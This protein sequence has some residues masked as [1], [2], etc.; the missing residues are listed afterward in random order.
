MLIFSFVF[1]FLMIRRPPI[2]TRT[3]TLFPYTTLCRSQRTD[4]G[5]APEDSEAPRRAAASATLWQ[6]RL[7]WLRQIK[8]GR[9]DAP[10]LL[11]GGLSSGI[12]T[13]VAMTGH[14]LAASNERHSLLPLLADLVISLGLEELIARRLD[15]LWSDGTTEREGMSRK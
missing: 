12:A 3:D 6:R 8:I 9:T 13:F 1:F 4:E 5:E 11:V 7:R 15:L 14:L 10:I 2:S